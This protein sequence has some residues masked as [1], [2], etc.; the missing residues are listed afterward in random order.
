MFLYSPRSAW[1]GQVAHS[2]PSY[3]IHLISI[4]S[5]HARPA[6]SITDTK[7]SLTETTNTCPASFNAGWFMYEGTCLLEHAPEN[8]AGT[9]T[10]TPF[11]DLNSSARL[12]LLPGESSTSTS[13]SGISWP[14]RTKARGV[15]WKLRA[16]TEGRARA[17]RRR[18]VRK[19]MIAFY[20]FARFDMRKNACNSPFWGDVEVS[21][22][23]QF[24]G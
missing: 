17:T 16:A 8:A 2:M 24:W 5:H 3:C 21:W 22:S 14:T 18:E 4:T 7:G 9:P 19:D 23:F 10:M 15:E 13:K 1:P 12:T 6:P 11:P 20:G